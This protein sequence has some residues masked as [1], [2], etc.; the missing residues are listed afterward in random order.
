MKG[1]EDALAPWVI[2]HPGRHRFGAPSLPSDE[3]KD[4]VGGNGQ[5][6]AGQRAR[7]QLRLAPL[8]VTVIVLE[9]TADTHWRHE[10]TGGQRAART[11]QGA[12]YSGGMGRF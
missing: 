8:C 3:L 6:T 12:S 11:P 7:L 1:L 9:K 2:T 10:S 5:I 4:Y